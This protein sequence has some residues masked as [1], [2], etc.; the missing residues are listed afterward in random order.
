MKKS[1]YNVKLLTL[2]IVAA[3]SGMASLPV[4]SA[5]DDDEL[6]MFIQVAPSSPVASAAKP[7]APASVA[8]PA[9]RT[10]PVAAAPAVPARV[11]A[12][13]SAPR[14]TAPA[15]NWVNPSLSGSFFNR[16]VA[17]VK[18]EPQ[19][20]KPLVQPPVTQTT[21]AQP[22]VTSQRPLF[23]PVQP[24][25]APVRAPLDAPSAV[26]LP[27]SS[28]STSS[29]FREVNTAAQPALTP[30]PSVPREVATPRR[31]AANAPSEAE[32]KTLFANAVRQS[33]RISPRIS[34]SRSQ[35]A[36]AE[37]SVDEAKGQRWPQVD[38]TSNSKSLYFG[39]GT[40]NG[41]SSS[42]VPSVGI[43][44]A[45]TL[46]D[47]GQTSNT[48]KTR[49]DQARAAT[50]SIAAEEENTAWELSNAMIELNKQRL[51][52]ALSEDFV[53]R[54]KEL[55][56][57]L[58]GIVAVDKGRS[59]ELTQAKGRLLTA[60]SSL[61]AAVSR[62]RDTEI[63]IYRLLGESQVALPAAAQ[64]NMSLPNL[65]GQL[66]RLD[67][68]PTILKAKADAQASLSEAAAVRSSGLP[69]LNWVVSKN[70]GEDEL[71]RTQAFQTGL[72]MSWGLFRGGSNSAAERAALARAEANRHLVD[73][74]HRDL[75]QRVR[76]ANQDAGSLLER[77]D[78]YQ[79]LKVESDRIRLAF[80]EQWYHLGKRTLLDVLSAESDYYNNRVSEVSSRFDGYAAI[81]RSYAS[82]GQ[83]IEWLNTPGR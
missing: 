25:T 83:L 53:A 80:F 73:E 46:Y 22:P 63:V 68:H 4:I 67:R 62:A 79:N 10:M 20:V 70:T 51:I 14:R 30:M 58:S 29:Y 71:G 50:V 64:W 15:A 56:A 38:L 76:A 69:S 81:M 66:A 43:N 47:F 37:S 7:V 78:L 28:A 26:S 40:R 11:E 13:Q 9:V 60:Q 54:M 49:Q 36:A 16:P 77:A 21:V 65:N 8:A 23:Q 55:T 61:D 52:I 41:G 18:P 17:P 24:A 35:A 39:S 48:I 6:L 59:S 32:I 72:Q 34:S 31:T 45:T 3:L 44:V 57:M 33:L 42:D 27:T 12:P 5:S 74:Q 1:P 75:E 19:P 2:A 82:S